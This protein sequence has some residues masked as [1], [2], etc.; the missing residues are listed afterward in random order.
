LRREVSSR[1]RDFAFVP[2]SILQKWS[3]VGL[4]LMCLAGVSGRAFAD[5]EKADL[6]KPDF[7]T[8]SLEELMQ[9]KIPTVVAA[10]KHEQKTTEAP[11]SV[12]IVTT[13]SA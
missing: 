8:Q 4:I 2:W 7:T 5:E 12:S 10:S 3:L 13:V 11:A 1:R 6:D 9:V